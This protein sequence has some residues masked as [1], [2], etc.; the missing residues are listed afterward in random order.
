MILDVADSEFLSVQFIRLISFFIILR[1]KQIF[2][3]IE[4][5]FRKWKSMINVRFSRS[6]IW[7]FNVSFWSYL[8]INL[9]LRWKNRILKN[10]QQII[11][12]LSERPEPEPYPEGSK[13]CR[14]QWGF[15]WNRNFLIYFAKP[16]KTQYREQNATFF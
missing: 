6:L 16:E 9:K 2:L 14:I 4:M 3:K 15:A 13:K 11:Y 5:Y 1:K 8:K 7:N 12:K 10:N